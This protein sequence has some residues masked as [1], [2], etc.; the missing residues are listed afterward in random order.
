MRDESVPRPSMPAAGL[1]VVAMLAFAANSLL[2]RLAL[3]DAHIDAASFGAVRVVAGAV[4]LAVVLQVVRARARARAL[5]VGGAWPGPQ[6]ARAGAAGRD[7]AA[8]GA[9]SQVPGAPVSSPHAGLFALTA[10]GAAAAPLGAARDAMAGTRAVTGRLAEAG[11]WW[12]AWMLFAYVGCFSFAYLRLPAGTG[13]LILFAAVQLT[14]FGTGLARGERFAPAGWAGLALAAAGLLYLLLPGASTPALAPALLMAA[15]GATWGVYSLRG[16][17]VPDPL[18]ATA[19]NFA[20]AARLTILLALLYAFQAD[21][22]SPFPASAS[23]AAQTG[24]HAD[25]RG[26]TLAIISGALTSGLGYVIWYSA[27]RRL[28]AL[29]T[30]SVQLSVP[31]LAAL[32]GAPDRRSAH[33]APVAGRAGHPRRHRPGP[34]PPGHL[35]LARRVHNDGTHEQ[36]HPPRSHHAHRPQRH[37]HPPRPGRQ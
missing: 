18:A 9:G 32:G 36:H 27:L 6:A 10:R 7:P 37:L 13:A 28:T 26:I 1:T 11:D 35:S 25:A 8:P 4:M 21:L 14:M 23:P 34:Q 24:M 15:A 29:Q 17:G 3:R 31:V 33:P 22:A 19:A 16:R 20:R 30:A 2:C 12:A 5:V